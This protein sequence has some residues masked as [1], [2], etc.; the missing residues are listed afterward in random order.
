MVQTHLFREFHLTHRA[1]LCVLTFPFLRFCVPEY[2]QG[3]QTYPRRMEHAIFKEP[4]RVNSR[5][6]R[7]SEIVPAYLRNQ[8]SSISLSHTGYLL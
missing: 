7:S 5:S 2:S 6:S 3:K 8:L 1:S 4:Y